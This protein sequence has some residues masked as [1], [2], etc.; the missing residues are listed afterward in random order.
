MIG[1]IFYNPVR[2]GEISRSM[3]IGWIDFVMAYLSDFMPRSLHIFLA[4]LSLISVCRGT[5]ERLF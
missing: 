2:N 4:R 1:N 5:D 3:A